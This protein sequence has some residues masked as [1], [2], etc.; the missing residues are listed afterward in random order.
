MKK[1]GSLRLVR[2]GQTELLTGWR[3]L[4]K[5]GNF[6]GNSMMD[7]LNLL[8]NIFSIIKRIYKI[9]LHVCLHNLCVSKVFP[10]TTNTCLWYV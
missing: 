10:P 5:L 6:R 9:Y 4:V 1:A 8:T 7:M 2:R 3:P